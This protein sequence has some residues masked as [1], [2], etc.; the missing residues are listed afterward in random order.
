MMKLAT[1]VSPPPTLPRRERGRTNRY[2]SYVKPGDPASRWILSGSHG[3]GWGWHI[4]H[5]DP[6]DFFI[7][8]MGKYSS[9]QVFFFTFSR[10]DTLVMSPCLNY[11]NLRENPA[12]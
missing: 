10:Y 6:P 2:A 4:T 1:P 9:Y 12:S 3:F 5:I 7:F 8:Y 11:C